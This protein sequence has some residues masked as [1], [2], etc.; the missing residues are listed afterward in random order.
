[1]SLYPYICKYGQFP[2]GH[3]FVHVGDACKDKEACLR[4]EGVI[5]CSI[6]PPER[7]YHIVLHFR[8]NQKPMFSLCQ[9]CV[10]TSHTGE[11]HHKKDGKGPSLEHGSLMN[12]GCPCRRGIGFLRFKKCMN[13]KLLVTTPKLGREICL[14][15]I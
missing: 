15:A 1:M 9:T 2:V 12:F 10:L 5:K 4:K 13:T 8:A 7:L 3:P 11:C 6:V 14:Q